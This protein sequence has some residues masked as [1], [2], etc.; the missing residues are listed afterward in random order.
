MILGL[1]V[2]RAGLGHAA[3][4]VLKN[5]HPTQH[6]IAM[7]LTVMGRFDHRL[8]LGVPPLHLL[9]QYLCRKLNKYQQYQP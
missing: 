7:S 1:A 8:T 2:A 4:G 6:P 5:F 3:A 9:A